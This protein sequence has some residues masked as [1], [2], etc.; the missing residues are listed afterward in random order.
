MNQKTHHKLL[1]KLL[2]LFTVTAL[3][4]LFSVSASAETFSGECGKDFDNLTWS[5]DDETETLSIQ[6]SG[7]MGNYGDYGT[8]WSEYSVKNVIIGDG[9]TSVGNRAFSSDGTPYQ[10]N[11]QSVVLP[12][13]LKTIGDYAFAYTAIKN[14]EIPAGVESIGENA[15]KLCSSLE[16]IIVDKNN[17]YYSSDDFGVLFNK[18]KTVLIQYPAGNSRETYKTPDSVKTLGSY[19]FALCQLKNIELTS[20]INT[21][22]EGAIA[23]CLSLKKIKIPTK[24]ETIAPVAF[25]ECSYLEEIEIPASVKSIGLDAFGVCLSLESIKVDENNPYFSSD[26]FGVLFNKDKTVLLQYPAGN[27]RETYKTP[28]SVKTIGAG[29]FKGCTNLRYVTLNT[30]LEV[31]SSDA[32]GMC[33]RL[34][35]VYFPDTLKRIEEFAFDD[36]LSLKNTVL[37]KNLE[38]VEKRAFN[39][40]LLD[41]VITVKGQNTEFENDSIVKPECNIAEGKFEEFIDWVAEEFFIENTKAEFSGQPIDLLLLER[42][43]G[44]FVYPEDPDSVDYFPTIRCHAGSTAETYAKNNSI[45]YETVHFFDDWSYD[46][47]NLTRTGKCI[48]CEATTGTETLTKTELDGVEVIARP[49]IGTELF[50]DKITESDDEYA[51]FEKA[52]NGLYDSEYSVVKI[53]NISFKNKDGAVIQPDGISRVRFSLENGKSGSYKVYLI[54]DDGTLTDMNAVCEGDKL[55]F[56]T[57]NLYRYIIVDEKPQTE[58]NSPSDFIKI[59]IDLF[60]ELINLIKSFFQAF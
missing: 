41:S 36:C 30:N 49:V 21:I 28:D 38:H 4:A 53:L 29:A 32:F 23:G 40:L 2:L 42:F 20:E 35:E 11:I 14:I 13:T 50:V 3:C 25:A 26:D 59:I 45:E 12:D 17:Q 33:I 44:Y 60:K 7:E 16:S 9:V 56:D 10:Y 58:S 1:K 51:A 31:I 37:P 46:W 24:V 19:S 8:P 15:F 34:K 48:S 22:E 43:N 39:G 47:E 5:Y 57:D 54:N 6:G 27:S 52:L 55:V 18:D